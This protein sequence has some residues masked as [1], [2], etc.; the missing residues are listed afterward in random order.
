MISQN[1]A[2]EG[3]TYHPVAVADTALSMLLR[4]VL[5]FC[6]DMSIRYADVGAR[7]GAPRRIN[8]IAVTAPKQPSSAGRQL[9]T[10]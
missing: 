8:A 7:Q 1:C 4:S 3:C 9:P 2:T 6:H 10:V 5:C